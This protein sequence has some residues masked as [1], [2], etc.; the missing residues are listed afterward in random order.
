MIRYNKPDCNIDWKR[1]DELGWLADDM[2]ILYVY[3]YV[4]MIPTKTLM[5]IDIRCI[6]LYIYI[7]H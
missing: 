7:M 6:A 2:L 3:V 5:L 1:F 4:Y